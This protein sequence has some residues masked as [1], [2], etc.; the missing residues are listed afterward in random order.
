MEKNYRYQFDISSKKFHCPSCQKK[1][2][3][4]YV[5]P[6]TGDYL[7][8]QYGKCDRE[9][10]CGHFLLPP[11]ETKCLFVPFDS[12]LKNSQKAYLIIQGA[13]KN[14]LPKAAV[15]EIQTAGAYVAEYFL[16]NST[17][18]PNYNQNDCKYYSSEGIS[19][20]PKKVPKKE[21]NHD[22]VFIPL[23][24]LKHTLKTESYKLNVFI[25]NLLF[26]VPYP[27][28]YQDLEEVIS[29]YFL[30]TISK[31]EQ[32][33]A[34]TFP[35]IDKNG[36]VNAI[37]VK[38]FDEK[39]HTLNK[40]SW[41]HSLLNRTSKTKPAWLEPYLRQ[42][43]KVSCLF[44]EHLLS[45]F[46]KNPIAL[47]EAPKTAI[48]GALYFGLPRDH[49]DLIWLAVFNLSSLNLKKCRVLKGRTVILFPDLSANGKAYKLWKTKTQEM[50][51]QMKGTHFI[52][53]DLLEF[54]ATD[55]ERRD[56]QDLADYLIRQDW[57]EFRKNKSEEYA[58]IFRRT[59]QVRKE[60]RTTEG[61]TREIWRKIKMVRRQI[62][63]FEVD[64]E[65]FR[66]NRELLKKHRGW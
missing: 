53:S 38:Q 47:V 12:I 24:I 13:N 44:G 11:L 51:R 16:R 17:S 58:A 9:I 31:G 1:T 42:D 32:K 56:G 57:R 34:I 27:F 2:F 39:N 52:V 40:P 14:Y 63:N 55:Q 36:K 29:T 43:L 5:D 15:M 62:R 41:I 64:E 66:T 54:N 21:K 59:K 26:R 22:Q 30:G 60:I 23:E 28:E 37:Q 19:Y 6:E 35:F 33:G 65:A 3:V 10:K 49:R 18:P 61:Q 50:Q 4:L 25:Q 8:E 45:T 20:T 46:P 7:P 48:Y